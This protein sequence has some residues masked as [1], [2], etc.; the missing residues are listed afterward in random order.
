[1]GVKG[2]RDLNPQ[3]GKGTGRSCDCVRTDGAEAPAP[4]QDPSLGVTR[5]RGGCHRTMGCRRR[6]IFSTK[7]I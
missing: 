2:V 5:E 6:N 7:L 1:M 3:V 4:R